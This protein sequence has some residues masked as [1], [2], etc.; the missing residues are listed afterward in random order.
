MIN[1]NAQEIKEYIYENDK[2][3]Y[4][5]Q[6]LDMQGIKVCGNYI[7]CGFPIS[8]DGK[9]KKSCVIYHTNDFLNVEAYTRDIKDEYGR[10]DIIN[11]VC[12]VKSLYFTES[13]KWICDTLG[14]DYYSDPNEDLPES[15]K[16]TKMVME[17]S[18]GE[19]EKVER[20][21]P[22][23]E[24]ILDYYYKLG[25]VKFKKEGLSY[26]TQ[27][28]FEVGYDLISDR[29]TIPIRDELGTLVGVKGR[30]IDSK[31]DMGDKYIYLEPCAKS[32]ILYG[33]NLTKKYI[34]E[35]S[36][37]IVVESE[38]SVMKLWDYGIKN[39][40][41]VGGHDLSRTQV[42]KLSRLCCNEIIICYDQ[43]VHR[44]ENGKI[45]KKL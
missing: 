35:K 11:L 31:T 22:I 7:Q 15:L 16:W 32:Q 19:K 20:L 29:I 1:I 45:L 43:D 26:S 34:K 38:K 42:E 21:K 40:V 23:N 3:E 8:L 30:R 39:A 41:A 33:L 24:K 12:F 27:R 14:L 6:E 2:I 13:L 44:G 10:S 36:E 9:S 18:K 4:I 17:V 5:L 28:I 37:V 25:S